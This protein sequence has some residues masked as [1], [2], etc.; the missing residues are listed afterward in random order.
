MITDDACA[1]CS[2]N[3]AANV[4]ELII[5]LAPERQAEKGGNKSKCTDNLAQKR[6]EE[7]E[8][9]HMRKVRSGRVAL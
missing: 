2:D 1:D 8:H 3:A 6:S 9:S 7:R 5:Q 4:W